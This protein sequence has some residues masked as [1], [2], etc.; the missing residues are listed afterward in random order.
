MKI[1]KTIKYSIVVFAV[2]VIL[3]LVINSFGKNT[4]LLNEMV[5]TLVDTA[6]ETEGIEVLDTRYDYGK[7]T[8]NGNG[9]EYYGA[10]LVK[11]SSENDVIKLVEELE[12]HYETADYCL[13]TDGVVDEEY[14]RGVHY[15][16]DEDVFEKF[17]GNLYSVYFLTTN[18]DS[19]MFDPKG[20]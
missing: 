18:E 4:F 1:Q 13:Q 3:G 5:K 16:V 7:L 14:V 15:M 8:G 9:I 10:I 17:S 2:V 6:K 11:A 12:S 20:H 19:N